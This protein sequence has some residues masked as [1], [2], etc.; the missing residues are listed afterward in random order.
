MSRKKRRK[1]KASKKPSRFS[2]H[3]L[4]LVILGVELCWGGWETAKRLTYVAT[5][6]LQI[7][8]AMLNTQD[9]FR[10]QVGPLQNQLA[11]AVRIDQTAESWLDLGMLYLTT[12]YY[13][14]AEACFK[15]AQT[16]DADSY[17]IAYALGASLDLLGQTSEA[18]AQYSRASVL[19]EGRLREANQAGDTKRVDEVKRERE[20][21]LYLTGK[22]YLRQEDLERAEEA[23]RK[24]YTFQP[25]SYEL[26]K[27]LL[28]TDRIDEAASE[29]RILIHNN[30]DALETYL[31]ASKLAAAQ[32]D[33][34]NAAKFRVLANTAIRK[35]GYAPLQDLTLDFRSRFPH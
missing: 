18:I 25:A 24:I 8:P 30:K 7:D 23:F 15:H 28:R 29:I 9:S 13:P 34:A 12:G 11:R 1:N 31:V 35:V 32:G 17:D 14:Q 27:I 22:C 5:P 26:M 6:S 2:I 3:T 19:A 16:L 21:S 20:S 4:L 10:D 33:S